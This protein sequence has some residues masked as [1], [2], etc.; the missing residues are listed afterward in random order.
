MKRCGGTISAFYLV[1]DGIL[2][3]LHVILFQQYD[4][5]EK[6]ELGRQKI[7]EYKGY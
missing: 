2:K 7:S 5:L 6:A 3:R 1:K 4:I